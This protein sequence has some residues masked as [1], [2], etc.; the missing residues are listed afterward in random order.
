M[1]TSQERIIRWVIWVKLFEY[2]TWLA[3]KTGSGASD[4]KWVAAILSNMFTSSSFDSS[5]RGD[6]DFSCTDFAFPAWTKNRSPLSRSVWSRCLRN[7]PNRSNQGPPSSLSSR[8]HV[9]SLGGFEPPWGRVTCGYLDISIFT[10][11]LLLLEEQ[12]LPMVTSCF[13]PL[14]STFSEI[15]STFTASA[16]NSDLGWKVDSVK[17][18]DKICVR[19]TFNYSS[20]PV[21]K[22]PPEPASHISR[23]LGACFSFLVFVCG[24]F[25]FNRPFS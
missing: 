15:V 4:T 18:S 20:C 25:L 13:I 5:L 10:T 3:S 1:G 2:G 21:V 7:C 11:L 24:R 19:K 14:I 16:C 6:P 22:S 8:R 23:R 9:K 17:K 12:M